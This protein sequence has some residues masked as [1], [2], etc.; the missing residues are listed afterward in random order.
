L[1]LCWPINQLFDFQFDLI[2]IWSTRETTQWQM[3]TQKKK[4]APIGIVLEFLKYQLISILLTYFLN[5]SFSYFIEY[6][7]FISNSLI[8]VMENWKKGK[9][10][11]KL[12]LHDSD[13]FQIYN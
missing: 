8:Y 13:I 5:L 6:I 2:N 3:R 9:K 4:S 11:S 10:L 7:T 12:F 1:S